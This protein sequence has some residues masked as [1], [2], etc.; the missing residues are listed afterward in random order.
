M[1]EVLLID[2]EELTDILLSGKYEPLIYLN[3]LDGRVSSPKSKKALFELPILINVT[4]AKMIDDDS[5]DNIISSNF[6]VGN[7]EVFFIH[8]AFSSQVVNGKIFN[9]DVILMSIEQIV[10]NYIGEDPEGTVYI[11]TPLNMCNDT[12]F[13][14]FVS[15]LKTLSSK[16]NRDVVLILDK[17][18][19]SQ[20]YSYE[21]E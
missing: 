5:I 9:I 11:W 12:N 1:A 18:H 2:D 4:S 20:V 15:R 21:S 3:T 7:T 6:I 19:Q 14:E 8:D 17:I 13:E 16:L 10:I